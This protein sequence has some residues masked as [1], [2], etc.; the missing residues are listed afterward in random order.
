MAGKKPDGSDVIG[1]YPL[2]PDGTCRFL[3]FDF[4]NHDKGAEA[5]DFANTDNNWFDEVNAMREI[6]H[7]NQIPVLIERS[8]SGKGAHIWIFF[9]A[10]VSASLARKFGFALLDKGAES[11]NLKTFRYYDRMLPA[12]D[13]LENENSVGNVIALPLQGQALKNGNSAFIDEN[14]D[15]Y[16]DQWGKLFSTKKFSKADLENYLKQW[17]YS[18]ITE[19]ETQNNRSEAGETK[20]WT[21]TN[22]FHKED[23]EGQFKIILSN[24]IYIYAVNL[25][26]RLQNQIRRLARI[27][28]PV[29]IKNQKIGFSNYANSKY[30]YL[31][32]DEGRYISLPRGIL[33]TLLNRCQQAG[34]SYVIEDERCLGNSIAIEFSGTMRENQ[35]QAVS[36]LIQYDCGILSAATA[37]GKTVV[38][39]NIIAQ[40][41]TSTLILL[42]SSALIEQWIKSLE[43]FLRINEELPEYETRMGRKKKRKSLIGIIQ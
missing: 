35:E 6:C 25:K 40:K 12:Q 20:P 32:E 4:D 23:V 24:R 10:P 18:I 33:E 26:P 13:Y 34:I 7:I 9:A 8:R 38:C 19:D 41:K 1:V 39:G 3:V 14:W 21:L 29:F 31:G 30:I 27:L 43:T 22:S 17:N 5:N 28:N 2:F 37:F 16:P 15:A 36:K 11:V 42:E